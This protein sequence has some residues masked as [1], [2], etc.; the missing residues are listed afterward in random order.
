MYIFVQSVQFQVGGDISTI[1]LLHVHDITFIL[2]A[3]VY[4]LLYIKFTCVLIESPVKC[5]FMSP[6]IEECFS[7]THLVKKLFINGSK[8]KTWYLKM[9][10]STLQFE[11]HGTDCRSK[12]HE[13]ALTIIKS[14]YIYPWA[15]IKLMHRYSLEWY[16]G[17]RP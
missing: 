16:Q 12:E 10:W 2:Y 1:L 6:S 11:T 7:K 3:C 5:A 15:A 4:A 9:G 14:L 17:S 13:V 8:T